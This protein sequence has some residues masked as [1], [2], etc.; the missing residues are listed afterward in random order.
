MSAKHLN[1]VHR[2]VS[3]A[4]EALWLGMPRLASGMWFAKT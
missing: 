2:K 4:L 3:E 1:Q